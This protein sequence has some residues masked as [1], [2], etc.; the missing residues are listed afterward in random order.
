MVTHIH[1]ISRKKT[2]LTQDSPCLQSAHSE[3]SSSLMRGLQRARPFVIF[4]QIEVDSGV[5]GFQVAR[6]LEHGMSLF[7]ACESWV[8]DTADYFIQKHSHRE[9]TVYIYDEHHWANKKEDYI[10]STAPHKLILR[11][12]VQ[13]HGWGQTYCYYLNTLIMHCS[14]IQFQNAMIIAETEPTNDKRKLGEAAIPTIITYLCENENNELAILTTHG[15]KN[16]IRNLKFMEGLKC[17]ENVE[18]SE[19]ELHMQDVITGLSDSE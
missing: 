11:T 8:M 17:T 1:I 7:K 12:E 5:E 3:S 18:D 19:E 4:S 16:W 14:G 13:P 2:N 9:N 6:K 15:Y 10:I